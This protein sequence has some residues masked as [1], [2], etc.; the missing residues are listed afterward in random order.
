MTA[1]A[2]DIGKTR[3]DFLVGLSARVRL[4]LDDG[5]PELQSQVG[6]ARDGGFNARRVAGAQ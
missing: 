5:L 2:L 4:G 6:V 3:Q 1:R